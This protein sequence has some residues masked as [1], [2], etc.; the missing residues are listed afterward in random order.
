MNEHDTFMSNGFGKSENNCHWAS[1]MGY[2]DTDSQRHS[3]FALHFWH[4]C[5]IS[6]P[7]SHYVPFDS[8]GDA[9]GDWLQPVKGKKGERFRGCVVTRPRRWWRRQRQCDWSD[10]AQTTIN[11]YIFYLRIRARKCEWTIYAL[12]S[13]GNRTRAYLVFVSD[14]YH[15]NK[16]KNTKITWELGATNEWREIVKSEWEIIWCNDR[17][18]NRKVW[19]LAHDFR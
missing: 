16:K 11:T 5:H 18:L 17:M 7:Q 3:S 8:F 14:F 12:L 13:T 9:M 6:Q 15:K 1:N 2:M 4:K 10:L 19:V